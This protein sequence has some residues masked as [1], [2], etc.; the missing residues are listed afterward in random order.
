MREWVHWMLSHTV[1]IWHIANAVWLV[2]YPLRNLLNRFFFSPILFLCSEET[3]CRINLRIGLQPSPFESVS[4]AFGMRLIDSIMGTTAAACSR[5]TRMKHI[6]LPSHPYPPPHLPAPPHWHLA[7][8]VNVKAVRK[9]DCVSVS[10]LTDN[11]PRRLRLVSDTLS[12]TCHPTETTS[13]FIN[14]DLLYSWMATPQT[15]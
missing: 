9:C 7:R 10:R 15:T 2:L 14:I 3:H 1:F 12:C 11:L 5:M 13:K 6:S 4:L 8:H